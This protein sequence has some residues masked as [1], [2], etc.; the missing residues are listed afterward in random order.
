M[1]ARAGPGKRRHNNWRRL[2][3]FGGKP[4]R[5][6]AGFARSPFWIL[7][8]GFWIAAEQ[9]PSKILAAREEVERL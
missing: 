5:P 1:R 6:S 3:G 8:L 2:A 4:Q 7:D 9:D